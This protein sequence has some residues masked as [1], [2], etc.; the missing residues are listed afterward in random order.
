MVRLRLLSP[1]YCKNCQFFWSLCLYGIGR[2]IFYPSLCGKQSGN[3][4]W[5]G[6]NSASDRER[7]SLEG[8][9]EDYHR[10]GK[11]GE[12]NSCIPA[13]RLVQGKIGSG[14]GGYSAE[15]ESGYLYLTNCWEAG[16]ELKLD[17]CMEVRCVQANAKSGRM[18]EGSLSAGTCLLLYGGSG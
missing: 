15:G 1:Q 10:R 2:Y 11:Q 6:K 5:R 9:C 13:S 8:Q 7:I 16:M 17:F 4:N 3:Q 12:G 14:T 18:R